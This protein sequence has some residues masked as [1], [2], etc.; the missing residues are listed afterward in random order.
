LSNSIL[1][2]GYYNP[3]NIFNF[4]QV[5]H[6]GLYYGQD[7]LKTKLCLRGKEMM[8]DLCKT[9]SIPHRNTGKWIVAQDA[10][11]MEALNKI[12]AFASTA[13]VPTRFLS[14]RE[15]QDREPDVRADAGVL[16]SSSTG[17]V[18]SH[19][20]MQFLEGTFEDA[21]GICAFHS[22]V[23]RV[24]A[25]DGGRGGWAVTTKEANGEEATITADSI[26]NSAGLYAVG[27]SNMILP[28]ERHRE[29]FYAKGTYF[30][31]SL[32]RP[33]PSTL[34]YPAPVPGHGMYQI[35]LH[36]PTQIH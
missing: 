35:N 36:M 30:S 23:T 4:Q 26:V 18:D 8:Y 12:H 21:G 22:P 5:I 25:I 34:I 19:A 1:N 15:A 24:E 11:Q 10:A 7:S 9:H 20:L 16:E 32:S 17:I 28:K 14:K 29:A 33:Q 6:A 2:F 3:V 27:I 31:Y 13:G